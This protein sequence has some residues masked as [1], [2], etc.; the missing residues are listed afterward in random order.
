MDD[1]YDQENSDEEEEEEVADIQPK[2]KN[3]KAQRAGV[4]AKSTE[5]GTR[6]ATS[7]PRLCTRVLK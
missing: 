2:K 4:S 7:S 1:G 6:K 3:V 5:T